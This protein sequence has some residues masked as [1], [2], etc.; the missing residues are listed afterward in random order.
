LNLGTNIDDALRD[1]TVRVPL[2][3]ARFFVSAVLL[4]KDTGGNLS[5]VLTNLAYIIRE[6]FKLKGMVQ[7]VSAQGRL[8]AIVLTV[9][10]IVLAVLLTFLAPDYLGSMLDDPD[11]LKILG[12]VAVMQVVGYLIM[13]Q[14]IDIKV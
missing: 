2:L 11:G 9:L 5:E 13:R 8:T 1:L 3:D 14:I 12:F 4:Q 6:R 7:A 10:P